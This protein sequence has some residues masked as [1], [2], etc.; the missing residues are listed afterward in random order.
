[1][2]PCGIVHLGLGAF[3]RAHLA[4][5]TEQVPHDEWG[6]CAVNVRANAAIVDTL[7]QQQYCYH[8]SEFRSSREVNLRPVRCV[9]DTLFAGD[10]SHSAQLLQ[11]LQDPAVKIV[12]LTVT[13]KGY[14]L[15]PADRM[16][17]H[18]HDAIRHDLAN[19]NQPRTPIG[20]LVAALALR[21][22]NNQPLFTLLSCDNMPANGKALK[23]ALVQF[24]SLIDLDLAGWI[25]REVKCP[26]TMVDRIVPAMTQARLDEI[27][28]LIQKAT[29]GS[30]R[31]N[32]AVAC[33]QFSQWVIEDDFAQGRPR[34]ELAGAQF[35]REVEP[36]ETMKLRMLNGCHSLLAYLGNLGSWEYVTDCMKQPD[37]VAL[38]RHYLRHEAQPT[39]HMPTGIDLDVYA[40]S[41]LQRF[42]NDSL[43]HR[44]AQIAMDGS[45][46]IPQRWLA[47]A[48]VLLE[49]GQLP[50]VTA[51]GIA[52]WL[53]YLAGIDE[54]GGH[55]P[56]DDPQAAELQRVIAG[57]SDLS[58]RVM[59]LLQTRVF[60]G[61][62]LASHAAFVAK[63]AD[64][65]RQLLQRGARAT[66]AA[67]VASLPP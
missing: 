17:Q 28:A 27:N 54:Q 66:V 46:K 1:M 8:V 47:G 12:S 57:H 9:R 7:K 49:R 59:A 6:I 3:M 31:D 65:H 23:S 61:T 15:N 51:L 33:E 4:V 62:T 16:L 36:F 24:A 11:R 40:D 22:H 14:Y 10:E 50:V 58:A 55:Y 44:T 41:L 43:K 56:V 53:R 2:Q 39:L 67:V 5:Y 34:W 20:L 19:P 42:R 45:L 64:C 25:E 38:I 48:Q 18:D 37:Y 63:V 13:E 26:S 29:P 21:R 52:A 35:V 60:A 30:A 32:A